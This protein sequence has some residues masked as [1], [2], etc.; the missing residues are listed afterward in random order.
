MVI[1]EKDKVAEAVAAASRMV[2]KERWLEESREW[3]ALTERVNVRR[4]A[5]VAAP[6]HITAEFVRL[7]TE[8]WEEADGD[9]YLV[10]KAK[11]VRRALEGVP[12]AIHDGELIVGSQTNHVRGGVPAIWG[13]ASDLL[14]QLSAPEVSTYGYGEA[15]RAVLDDESRE[16]LLEAARWW[17][18]RS[19][20]EIR[21]STLADAGLLE[22]ADDFAEARIYKPATDSMTGG[23]RGTDY[24]KLLSRGLDWVITTAQEKMAGLSFTVEEQDQYHFYKAVII[25]CE[26]VIAW[27][28]RYAAL[29]REMA[30]GEKDP[31]RKEELERIAEV[32]E[33]VPANPARD[34]YEALQSQWFIHLGQTLEEAMWAVA[35]GRVDQ[36]WYPYYKRDIEEGRITREQ[37]MELVALFI[38]KL[39]EIVVI[40][41]GL[42][43]QNA[44]GN[45]AQYFTLGGQTREGEDAVNELTFLVL[46][47]LGQVRL[48]QPMVTFRWHGKLYHDSFIKALETN[49]AIKGGI[50]VFHNDLKKIPDLLEAGVSLPD[51]RE[52]VIHGCSEPAILHS[53]SFFRQ[54][55][56]VG[57][58][59]QLELVLYN[60]V[61][62]RTGKQIGPA[63]GDP[64]DFKTFEEFERAWEEQFA[65]SAKVCCDISR[66]EWAVKVRAGPC[67]L[68]SALMNDCL[69][70]GKPALDGGARYPQLI[71]VPGV[72]SGHQNVAD[73]L[74]AIK[75]LVFEEKRL[76][77][78]EM[79]Q[80]CQADFEGPEHERV[81]QLLLDARKYG[82]DDDV[83]DEM[84]NRVITY[85]GEVI[86]QQLSPYGKPNLP[87]TSPGV[88]W[89][90]F[91]GK[92]VG[93][94]PDGKKGYVPLADATL[95]PMRGADKKGPTAVFNSAAKLNLWK[96]SSVVFNQ[97]FSPKL[98]E[99][100]AKLEKLGALIVSYFTRGGYNV[101]L[102]ILDASE[103]MEA[104]K[105]PSKYRDLVVRVAGYSANFVQLAPEV[106]DEI[107][108]RTWQ[109]I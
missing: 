94:M 93:A 71:S 58:A 24:E 53:S 107:I 26:G 19:G 20:E 108:E 88:S 60:G 76:S 2:P 66:V 27:A 82:N 51:A 92:T 78:D 4:E 89:H 97:K 49:K 74:S 62:T 48:S 57:V 79:I 75:Q 38:I 70:K 72:T 42:T 56:T 28:R 8:A 15:S 47:A 37:A 16:A 1:V 77:M 22:V 65:H 102:N 83:A 68:S 29:A 33:W 67:L 55:P 103:L 10:R 40:M 50:P 36:H 12:I 106:Q 11:A 101:Q 59:K 23:Q 91:H 95:S 85:T 84:L 13:H 54:N 6:Q 109:D 96:R 81:R 44:Q 17:N 41:D 105:H 30:Q 39:N 18:G 14:E 63:T 43:R 9:H 25:Q 98:L 90:Y 31:V 64:R 61:D 86:T 7:Y 5:C 46:Q 99:S 34:F 69:E 52:W 35:P 104:K 80:A 100:R 73:S 45:L 32:C 21:R 3:D 87:P